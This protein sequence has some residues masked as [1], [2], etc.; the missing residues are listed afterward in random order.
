MNFI[1]KLF[2]GVNSDPIQIF[3]SIQWSKINSLGSDDSELLDI[4]K[5][6]NI[7]QNY[8]KSSLNDKQI[9][10]IKLYLKTIVKKLPKDVVE[11]VSR[12]ISEQK[13]SIKKEEV[14]VE[15]MTDRPIL[16][17]LKS[18][19]MVISKKCNENIDCKKIYNEIDWKLVPALKKEDS[20]TKETLDKLQYLKT[21]FIDSFD[22][23][24]QQLIHL[25]IKILSKKLDIP[26][27]ITESI[28]K[29]V[30]KKYCKPFYLNGNEYHC[31]GT[32]IESENDSSRC[33]YNSNKIVNKDFNNIDLDP[34][35]QNNREYRSKFLQASI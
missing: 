28:H 2:G 14:V 17:E 25:Y 26:V 9:S 8:H 16:P 31:I 10:L 5:K 12:E 15:P 34:F 7:L 30:G 27:S 1:Y 4:Y 35:C 21:N 32:N 3:N 23:N 19:E 11:Q 33:V 22:Q 29:K 6:L 20:K 13:D 24:S 18:V